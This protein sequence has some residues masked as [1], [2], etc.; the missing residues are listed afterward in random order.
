MI[1][2][3]IITSWKRISNEKYL[4]KKIDSLGSIP[5]HLTFKGLNYFSFD[6]SGNPVK[7]W[8]PEAIS[9]DINMQEL[10]LSSPY[11][12]IYSPKYGNIDIKSK[13]SQLNQQKRNI[14]LEGN[15]QILSKDKKFSLYSE[16]LTLNIE[17]STINFPSN[18]LF[19]SEK[20]TLKS[21][22]LKIDKNNKK[23]IFTKGIAIEVI[24]NK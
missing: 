21:G 10:Y 1:S 22:R 8:A 24:P 23:A 3:F 7:V 5:I 11:I 16:K 15:V 6:N 14:N 17:K 12:E 13:K 18:T 4:S 9:N 20:G 19:K 2:P